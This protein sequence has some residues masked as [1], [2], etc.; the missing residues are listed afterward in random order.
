M[1]ELSYKV[2]RVF[3]NNAVLARRGEDELVLV[4]R[5]IG[6]GRRAGDQI[7]AD[8]VQRQYVEISPDKA[9][10]LD[11]VNSIDSQVFETISAAI[12]L[13]TDLLG[14]LHPSVY[15]VLTDHLAFAVQRLREGEAITN[16][17]LSEIRV[18]FPAEFGAAELMLSYINSHLD[19]ELPVDEAAF[20]TLHLSAARAGSTVKQPLQQANALAGI[21]E[22]AGSSQK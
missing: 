12:D 4:G 5:G 10:Y 1:A 3:S 21:V 14:E 13:A 22:Y 2:A 11:L 9:Q 7:A 15:L 19:A 8:N 18:V 20:I 17:L 16:P 6:F